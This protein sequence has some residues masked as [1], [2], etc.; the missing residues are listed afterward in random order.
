MPG[1]LDTRRP[2]VAGILDVNRGSGVAGYQAD[3]PSPLPS[4]TNGRNGASQ[5][6]SGIRQLFR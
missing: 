1:E 5:A 6:R 3:R 2:E 4:E